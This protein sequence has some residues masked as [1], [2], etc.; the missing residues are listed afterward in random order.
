MHFHN[1]LPERSIP[2][3]PTRLLYVVLFGLL[4]FSVR[5]VRSQ[6]RLSIDGPA[7]MNIGTL[8]EGQTTLRKLAIF[9]NGNT[10]LHIER[11]WTSCGC[12]AAALPSN[13]IPPGERETLSV[14]F[15]TKDLQGNF[16]REVHIASNDAAK[17][18]FDMS[19]EGTIV[20]VVLVT[21]RY[22]SFDRMSLNHPQ[23]RTVR[24]TNTIK[25]TVRIRSY[26]TPE[27]QMSLSLDARVIP[28]DSSSQLS[29]DLLPVS[30][31]KVL[32]QIELATDN[33][34]KPVIRISYI[35]RVK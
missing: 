6:P 30:V 21:P 23:H 13:D 28:P 15:D 17:P 26:S 11:L 29:V 7:A 4:M 24:I 8:Y 22:V 20:P 1:S 35:G 10:A 2:H 31:G 12:T 32:G 14:S 3:L 34:L 5:N 16:R 19:F 9:N 18:Q 27:P 33:T 25:D